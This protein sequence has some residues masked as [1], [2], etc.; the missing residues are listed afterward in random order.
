MTAVGRR[1]LRRLGYLLVVVA[2]ALLLWFSRAN[3]LAI[4]SE[5]LSTFLVVCVLMSLGITVQT[6]NFL[7]LLAWREPLAIRPA[8]HAWA[9]ATALNYLGPFQPGLALRLAYFKSRGVPLTY[10]A[11]T[12]LRQLQLSMWTALLVSAIALALL[13]GEAGWL[14]AG[15]LLAIFVAWPRLLDEARPR[16]LRLRW[17]A[18]L[19]RHLPSLAIVLTPLPLAATR[20]FFLQHLLG[21]ALILFTYRQFE[22]V[23]SVAG[24]MLIAVGVYLSSLVA[25]LP[26]NLGI[27]DGLYVATAKS[28]G[29][30]STTAIALAILFRTAHICV[31]LAAA[32][33]TWRPGENS[34]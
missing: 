15:L 19:Q 12:T 31:C 24:A 4:Y 22:A 5:H 23:V 9:L 7:H 27:L 25:I 29:L 14:G 33:L 26:N 2:A 17:P 13:G 32:L 1:N 21:A 6:L 20:Y 30:D 28:G 8:I 11:A 34:K 3:L 16:L 18:W 10:T